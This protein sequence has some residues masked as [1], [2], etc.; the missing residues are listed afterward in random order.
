MTWL[1]LYF[2]FCNPENNRIVKYRTFLVES[3]NFGLAL[4]TFELVQFK[5]EIGSCFSF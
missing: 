5:I 3:Y 4:V 2:Q 1:N